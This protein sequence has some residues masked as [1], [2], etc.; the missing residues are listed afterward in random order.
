MIAHLKNRVI[1]GAREH[2]LI[3]AA[4]NLIDAVNA[5]P[6]G[7]KSGELTLA[8]KDV[9]DAINNLMMPAVTA[10]S[11]R[12]LNALANYPQFSTEQ[13]NGAAA[14]LKKVIAAN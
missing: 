12:L 3:D 13:V 7:Y 4:Q 9:Q 2:E 6:T 1:I 5:M 10:R 14:N 8:A 11:P